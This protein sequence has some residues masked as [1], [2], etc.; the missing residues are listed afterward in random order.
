MLERDGHTP[1]ILDLSHETFPDELLKRVICEFAPDVIGFTN[2]CIPNTPVIMALASR[3]KELAP[4]AKLIAGGQVPT[5]KPD[6]FL[7]PPIFDAVCLGEGET[8]VS[9]LVTALCNGSTLEGLKGVAYVD[10]RGEITNTGRAPIVKDL[11]ELPLPRWEGMLKKASFTN[12]FSASVETARGCPYQCSFCSIPGFF[13]SRPRYKS[14]TRIMNELRYLK[15]IGVTEVS[16]I[17]DSFATDIE[18][19]KALFESLLSERL[20]LKFGVQIR[21]DTVAN[22]PDL[23]A[24]A[25]RAGLYLAIVGFEGYSEAAMSDAAKGNTLAINRAASRILRSH[26]VCVYGTHIFGGPNMRWQDNFLTF[27]LGRKNSDVFRMTIYTPLLGSRIYKNLEES[28]RIRTTKPEDYYYGTY[29]IKDSHD[30]T[31]VKLSYFALQLLH[32][33]LPDTALMALFHSDAVV[34]TMNR[35]AYKGAFEFVIGKALE[36]LGVI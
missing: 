10:Q 7:K 30:P 34:R 35:R 11:D 9:N 31:L 28:G 1:R 36:A 2:D 12:G 27:L 15:S 3:V 20:N 6:L 13:G 14:V 33:M 26:G 32:Y 22:N 29:V 25:S 4:S 24:L 8:V 16:F 19:A 18:R 17:D 21:A 5:L 23:I